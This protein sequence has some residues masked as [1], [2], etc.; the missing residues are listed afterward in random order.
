[1]HPIYDVDAILLLATALSS[2]R[3]PAEL[4]EIIAATDLIQGVQG[5]IPSETKIGDAIA[6]LSR[7]GLL[8]AVDG[9]F[10]LTEDGQAMFAAQPR[11]AE[12]AELL[13]GIKARMAAYE[14]GE[15]KPPIV[16]APG[17]LGAAILA[18][19]SAGQGAGKNQFMPKPKSADNERRPGQRTRKPLPARRRK[20]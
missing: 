18:H 12:T 10:A 1:M 14:V 4:V 15:E 19:R 5:T 16:L 11:K 8:R 6:R 7:H 2:K 9:G 20:D 13:Y 17:Q 3:R